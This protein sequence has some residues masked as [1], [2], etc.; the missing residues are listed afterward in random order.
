MK[1]NYLRSQ[2]LTHLRFSL[3]L[4]GLL[5]LPQWSLAQG[6]AITAVSPTA[7]ATA[8]PRTSA[9]TITFNQA[10]TASSAAAFNLFSSQ[11]GG[12]RTLATPAT[13]SGNTLTFTPSAYDFLPGE[14]LMGT[15]TTAAQSNSA[16]LTTPYV[17]QFTTAT[18]P[19]PGTFGVPTDYP[20]GQ[21]LYNLALGDVNGDGLLD[22]IATGSSTISVLLGQGGGGFGPK[23]DYAT[24]FNPVN[25]AL[26]D[27]NGDGR[28]DIV[29]ANYSS[30]SASVLLGQA[31]GGFAPHVDYAIPGTPQD[32]A[33][34]DVNGDGRL[35]LVT[36]NLNFGTIGVMLGQGNG[37]F[38]NSASYNSRDWPISVQ[39]GDLNGDGRLDLVSA[40]NAPG[41]NTVSVRFGQVGGVFG[42][43]SDYI[44]GTRPSDVAL[45]DVSGDG[46]L[47]IVAV[48]TSTNTVSVLLGQAG[49]GF[50][51]KTD[52]AT[53]ANP[54][55]VTLGDVN[56]DG[57]LDIVTANFSNTTSVLLGPANGGFL[58]K[59]DYPVGTYAYA[60]ALGDVNGDG[61][62]DIATA[63]ASANTVSVLL[64]N[65]AP[66]SLTSFAPASGVV[67]TSVV[68]TGAGFIGT[69]AV[70]FN[71]TRAFSFV[72][73]SDVQLTV[74]VPPGAT[75]GPISL[76]T[77]SGTATSATP[78]IVMPSLTTAWLGAVSSDWFEAG[79]WTAGV[80]TA[81]VDALIPVVGT[82][83]PVLVNGTANVRSLTLA[84]GASLTQVGGM[85][86]LTGDLTANGT[87]TATGGL[88]ATNGSTQQVLGGT[89]A[90]TLQNLTI[91]AAGATLGTATS[92]RQVL[93]LLGD[94]A[95]T[96][97]SLTL[98]SSASA[99]VATDALV[100][101]N[102]GVVLGTVTVQ[103]AIDPSVN[104][105]LG[106]RHF[107]TPMSTST[108]GDLATT[109]SGGTFTPI[110]NPLY[111]T[112]AV[113]DL[114]K[115]YPTV[116]GYDDSRLALVNNTRGFDKG[117]FSPSTLNDPL[118]V[119]RGY[120]V[121][122]A[123]SQ[124][125][126]FRGTLTNGDQT[127]ALSS[128]RPSNVDGGWQ[129][130][131][132]PY[133][134]PLAYSLVAPSDRAGLEAAIYVYS[135]TSQ[136]VG[137]YRSYVNGIGDPVLPIG[138]GFFTRVAAGLNAATMTFRNSQRL[139]TPSTTAFQRTTADSRPLV[140]LT[141]AGSGALLDEAT[142]YFEQGATSGF[143]A[144]YDAEKLANPTGLNLSTSLVNGHQLS[145]D[146]QP[147]LG[148]SQRV[149]PL[150]VGVPAAGGY[151]FTA[152]QLLNLST[153]PV[154]L[155]DVQLGTLT[156]LHQQ[157]TY[158]FTVANAA[159][160]TTR[161]E[162]VFSPQQVLATV[163]ATLAQQV[164]LYPNPARTQVTL[165]LPLSLRQQPAMATLLDALGRIMRT[166]QLPAGLVTHTLSLTDMAPG[167]Y[168][169]RLTTE[170]GTITKKLVVD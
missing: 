103:R 28:L 60:V 142:V 141:L 7:N 130:L 10:L 13:V 19:G 5:A 110:V 123:A 9:P 45:G 132:N 35:D 117:F 159:L 151:T 143:D 168:S 83:Y 85:L 26:G 170:Q 39:L 114:V 27:V 152:S 131:G 51:P 99:G 153:V 50:V 11:R 108:V 148:T 77:P 127:L 69:T 122:I 49:G 16:T 137:R 112:A 119:G 109:T 169:L 146:G 82:V 2:G 105:G 63:N 144:A 3:A 20:V 21:S 102:G 139:T 24:A 86:L 47:D 1:N 84:S 129:L 158:Q 15:V 89:S 29:T 92:L 46:R 52:Y 70:T 161:F 56:G 32:V 163:P 156:D 54:N 166:Q 162:L 23:T 81:T 136:Y 160:N 44:V 22:L 101:N 116:F 164:A 59:V 167:V 18:T 79:N 61:R 31:G 111:N 165:D 38:V 98:R 58:P 93:T 36:A 95:T 155:R 121:N 120:A 149:V 134:A 154:Y 94:L 100:V 118:V 87:L 14:T 147:E 78:F 90:L 97:Q 126:T 133:P 125:V 34:G 12:L 53:G 42:P 76:T 73:N 74:V 145:I 91:G 6:L 157:P 48:S 88:L 25:I 57:R 107:S 17:Y 43:V 150:A 128:L 80:P 4:V 8:A 140:Q 71:G 67:G 113:P 104:P 65:V 66:A 96:G 72:V 64:G 68:L 62:L 138:Q 37:T 55:R 75:T 40:N 30:N 41:F 115:P 33:L 106:Y 124:V 135:S